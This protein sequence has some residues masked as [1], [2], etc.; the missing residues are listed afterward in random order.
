MAPK[1]RCVIGGDGFARSRTHRQ[2]CR[3]PVVPGHMMCEAHRIE[4]WLRVDAL[5]ARVDEL[6]AGSEEARAKLDREVDEF[7]NDY[8]ARDVSQRHAR[9]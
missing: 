4:A 1:E 7:K 8:P 6:I 2:K 3:E 9:E 5:A